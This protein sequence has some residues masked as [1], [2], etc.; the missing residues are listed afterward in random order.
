MSLEGFFKADHLGW[1]LVGGLG[2]DGER[3]GRRKEG[4]AKGREHLVHSGSSTPP[5][6]MN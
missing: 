3:K 4:I 2:G 6:L 5:E 1:W